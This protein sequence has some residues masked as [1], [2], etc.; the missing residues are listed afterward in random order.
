[1]I[2]FFRNGQSIKKWTLL[3]LELLFW[4]TAIGLLYFMDTDPSQ[5]SLCVFRLI[6]FNSC[7]G[8]GLGHSIHYALHLS[9]AQSIHEHLLGIP[10]ILIILFRIKQL[11]FPKKRTLYEI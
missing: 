4:V 9:F 5:P 7:P 8:C 6:G 3:N 10:A 11:S 2:E 1:M